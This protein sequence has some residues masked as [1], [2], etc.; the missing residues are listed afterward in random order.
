MI[1]IYP[2]RFGDAYTIYCVFYIL[3]LALPWEMIKDTHSI[4]LLSLYRSLS[5]PCSERSSERKFKLGEKRKKD[6]LAIRQHFCNVFSARV[7]VTHRFPE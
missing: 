4:H 1:H 5:L 3:A 2:F 7:V 6:I